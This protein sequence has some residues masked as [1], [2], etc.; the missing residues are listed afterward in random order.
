MAGI[1]P[2][3]LQNPSTSASDS[4]TTTD[5]SLG[6]A[7]GLPSASSITS[8]LTTVALVGAGAVA[9]YVAWPYL[10]AVR[11]AGVARK[12]DRR[13]PLRAAPASSTSLRRRARSRARRRRRYA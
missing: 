6:D 3:T 12:A 5:P 2:T 7:L 9:L 1:D 13:E 10:T 8:V 4:V 11:G